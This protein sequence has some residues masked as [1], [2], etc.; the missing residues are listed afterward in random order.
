MGQ[1]R[2]MVGCTADMPCDVQIP[3]VRDVQLVTTSGVIVSMVAIL[4]ICSKLLDAKDDLSEHG[5]WLKEAESL[6]ETIRV[7]LAGRLVRYLYWICAP[8]RKVVT[9][10]NPSQIQSILNVMLVR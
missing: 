6:M 5:S 9:T 1:V 3:M 2:S 7:C 10:R 4:T 8:R